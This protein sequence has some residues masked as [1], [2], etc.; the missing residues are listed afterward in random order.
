MLLVFALGFALSIQAQNV[1]SFVLPPQFVSNCEGLQFCVVN[2]PQGTFFYEIRS[3]GGADQ[4]RTITTDPCWTLT[5]PATQVRAT[6]RREDG[7]II[8]FQADSDPQLENFIGVATPNLPPPT[9]T[10]GN[11][12]FFTDVCNDRV[13]FVNLSINTCVD[14]G[15]WEILEQPANGV[16]VSLNPGGNGNFVSTKVLRVDATNASSNFASFRIRATA[17]I[18]GPVTRTVVLRL[19]N[20]GFFSGDNSTDQLMM[21]ERI[22]FDETNLEDDLATIVNPV[23]VKPISVNEI[24]VSGLRVYPNPVSEQLT[25]KYDARP[26]Q[27]RLIDVNGRTVRAFTGAKLGEV[28]TR[29]DVN[30]LAIGLYLL[31]TVAKNGKLSVTKVQVN[32]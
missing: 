25:V 22:E 28:S 29:I 24:S 16:Q 13:S 31:E 5:V 15:S 21:A 8:L 10:V 3:I 1:P 20:C 4:E 11:G 7:S 30:N 6:F 2:P 19:I 23:M 26:E 27:L 14:P 32:R 12:S 9:I 17:G 18:T